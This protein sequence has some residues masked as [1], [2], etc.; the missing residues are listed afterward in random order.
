MKKYTQEELNQAIGEGVKDFSGCDLSGLIFSN[1]NLS[2]VNLSEAN[3]SGSYLFRANLSGSYLSEAN[4]SETNLNGAIF[5]LG[6]KIVKDDTV[7]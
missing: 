2:G 6:W 3:L 4:L 5:A 1:A 7:K